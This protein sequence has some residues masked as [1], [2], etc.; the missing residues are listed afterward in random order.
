M[1]TTL[2]WAVLFLQVVTLTGVVV[3]IVLAH[4]ATERSAWLR[5]VLVPWITNIS[6]LLHDDTNPPV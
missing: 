4:I 6:R 5:D 1:T 3:A 2:L